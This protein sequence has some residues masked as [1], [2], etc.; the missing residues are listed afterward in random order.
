MAFKIFFYVVIK[1]LFFN[2][3]EKIF[4]DYYSKNILFSFLSLIK[5]ITYSYNLC[6]SVMTRILWV[7]RHAEREDNINHNWLKQKGKNPNNLKPDNSP[8]SI[9]GQFQA[10]ELHKRYSIIPIHE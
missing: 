1:N 5:K 3:V 7:V 10:D 2:K 8:L 4:L 6:F 9:R